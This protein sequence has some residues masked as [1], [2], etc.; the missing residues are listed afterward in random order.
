[1]EEHSALH[2]KNLMVGVEQV[3][4]FLTSDNTVISFFE[5]SAGDVETPLMQRLSSPRTILRRS[6]DPT[7]LVQGIIDAIIDLAIPVGGKNAFCNQ[8]ATSSR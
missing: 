5:H 4:M 3:S 1:M 6:N 2:E 8:M 7:M